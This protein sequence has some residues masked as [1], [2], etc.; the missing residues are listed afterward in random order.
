MI[1][2]ARLRTAFH[3]SPIGKY[4]CNATQD[5]FF[6]LKL[7]LRGLKL[8]FKVVVQLHFEAAGKILG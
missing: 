2:P 8:K 5:F 1:Y 3:V 7:Y 6:G 4:E